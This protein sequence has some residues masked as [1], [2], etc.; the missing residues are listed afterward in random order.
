M[1]GSIKGITIEI[2]GQ[3][4]KLQ[5]ALQ[6]AGGATGKLKSELKS[7]EKGLKF[8]PSNTELLTQKQKILSES[9]AGTKSRLDV[10]NEAQRQMKERL[11]DT[12]EGSEE[13]RKLRREIVSTEKDLKKLE[14][15]QSSFNVTMEQMSNK[16]GQFAQATEKAGN[17]LKPVSAAASAT[18]FATSK[19]A[20]D[21]ENA[22]AKVS[23]I[24][25][26]TQKPIIDLKKEIIAL[27]NETGISS[28]EVAN[29]VYDA[30]SAGQDTA[31]AVDFV[32]TTNQLAVAGFTDI[33]KAV[34]VVTTTLNAYQL[35]SEE[36]TRVSDILIKTQN[37]GKVTVDELADSIGKVIP[38]A[39][40]FG[41]GIEQL[42]ASYAILTANGIKS[43]DATSALNAMFT[44]MGT[45]GSKVDEI[46][47]EKTGKSFEQLSSSG[48]NMVEILEI[49]KEGAAEAGGTLGDM[50]GSVAAKAAK[51]FET[52]GLE[53]YNAVLSE[54]QNAQ[55]TTAV[56]FEKMQ[57]TSMKVKIALNQ[58]KNAGIEIGEAFLP[59]IVQVS[60]KVSEWAKKFS[61]L[62]DETKRLIAVLLGIASV[63]APIL[64]FVSKVAFF[65]QSLLAFLPTLFSIIKGIFVLL[66][67]NPIGI[68]VAAIGALIAYL[69][70]LYKTNEEF[71][72]KV[73]AVWTGIQKVVGEAIEFIVGIFEEWIG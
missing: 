62:S 64:L 2:N 57:T 69:V 70:H 60:E 51:T 9:I 28:A 36:A 72:E 37:L 65:V 71:R 15:T 12:A 21:F 39:N 43:V 66:A 42:G 11:G 46:L 63:A 27:S 20:S 6:D 16:V 23:T 49:V 41:V 26:E 55:G 73:Q 44:E 32:R 7:V 68:V 54:M 56:G 33:G 14:Q 13:Y 19:F 30:I 3:T 18:V 38:T 50:F 34:D 29:S 22:M 25:D 24:S 1:A 10:L 4:T 53:E 61:G 5:K 47:R 52:Q 40:S 31:K 58:I 59:I 67:A 35:E 48:K 17:A 45:T 8:D